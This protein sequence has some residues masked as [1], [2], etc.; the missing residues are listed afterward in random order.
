MP[1]CYLNEMGVQ[2]RWRTFRRPDIAEKSNGLAP[3]AS[4]PRP[5]VDAVAAFSSPATAG[6][7]AFF[8]STSPTLPETE[9]SGESMKIH[10]QLRKEYPLKWTIV[11]AL[12]PRAAQC[13]H[14]RN[15]KSIWNPSWNAR[16]P[17]LV[18]RSEKTLKYSIY[19]NNTWKTMLL[20]SSVS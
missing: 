7:G 10:Y 19:T 15:S 3:A 12:S 11:R 4:S 17:D 14:S 6:A 18:K 5:A 9:N 13:Y 2:C 16:R 1:S 20:G 8:S